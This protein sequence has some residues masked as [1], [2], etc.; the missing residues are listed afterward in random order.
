MH[1]HVT[2]MSG[3]R[4]LI[5]ALKRERELI[6]ALE[7]K[8][9]LISNSHFLAENTFTIQL[10]DTLFI[11]CEK[12]EAERIESFYRIACQFYISL[13]DMTTLDVFF[14]GEYDNYKDWL[15]Q[16][17][18]QKKNVEFINSDQPINYALL[19]QKI[20]ESSLP[21]I[22]NDYD[23]SNALV[24]RGVCRP[25]AHLY[26]ERQQPQTYRNLYEDWST[27]L[28]YQYK[29]FLQ[30]K[31]DQVI[32]GS[33]YSYHALTDINSTN[34]ISFSLP[35]L[36]IT[37]A[38]S[39]YQTIQQIPLAHTTIFCFGLYDFFK[40]IKRGNA[41]V[42]A[43]A[44]RA[45]MAFKASALCDDVPSASRLTTTEAFVDINMPVDEIVQ[46]RYFTSKDC[47]ELKCALDT[48]EERDIVEELQRKNNLA[49]SRQASEDEVNGGGAHTVSLHNKYVK[50]THSYA[51]NCRLLSEVKKKAEHVGNNIYFIIPPLPESYVKN[52]DD[53]LKKQ[54]YSFLETLA[55]AHFQVRDFSADRDFNYTDFFDGQHLNRYGA[56]KL[57]GK[58]YSAGILSYPQL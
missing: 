1:S 38:V 13:L 17:S 5:L 36:D 3:V 54:V 42:Y 41:A 33:S 20:T 4:R 25:F 23:G 8:E 14:V 16:F 19:T 43:N 24:N 44:H 56:E 2:F 28:A 9:F 10:I 26:Y 53:V 6:N 29:R 48:R 37:S 7:L 35:G 22:V 49:I 47:G 32:C 57:R 40:E 30:Q 52:L 12:F 11:L 50:Y 45:V 51:L 21:I 55:S 39:L 31:F 18:D 58:L 34:S 27:F 46:T 15:G